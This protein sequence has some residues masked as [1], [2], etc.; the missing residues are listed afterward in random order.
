MKSGRSV[1]TG[2]WVL[3]LSTAAVIASLVLSDSVAADDL[4]GRR[5]AGISQPEG[6]R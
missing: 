2:G 4:S 5:H 1:S 6:L 3:R